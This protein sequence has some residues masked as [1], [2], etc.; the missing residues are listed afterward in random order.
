MSK[1]EPPLRNGFEP[2][3]KPF[4]L[5][6]RLYIQL[7]Y[8]MRSWNYDLPENKV[9]WRT[10][11]NQE[12]RFRAL[13]GIGDLQNKKILDLGCGLGCFYGFLKDRG[14]QGE[15]TGID[16]LDLMVRG[17]RKRF[18]E[19]RFKK[20]DIL[21]NPPSEK[22]DYV[23]VNGVFNHK[24]KDN[25]A[26]I[27]QMVRQSLESAK[28]GMAFSLLNQEAG[29]FDSD[30]FYADPKE[31]EKRAQRWTGDHFKILKGYLQEDMT[32]HLYK[33]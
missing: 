30:L 22:W 14:W 4:N 2:L 19:A 17:A 13:A 29:W 9:G 11:E 18:P 16:I 25:W 24:V 6:D 33:N 23:F 7:F 1:P 12:L 27:E 3:S 10:R 20:G 26:W 32:V 28:G 15:Y 21:Q 5:Y 8:L 31:L